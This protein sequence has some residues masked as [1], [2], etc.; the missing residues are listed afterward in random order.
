MGPRTRTQYG[1]IMGITFRESL[2]PF[3]DPTYR[4]SRGLGQIPWRGLRGLLQ[5]IAEQGTISHLFFA[6]P[7]SPP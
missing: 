7:S 6:P 4:A 3:L 2:A 1:V 5:Q